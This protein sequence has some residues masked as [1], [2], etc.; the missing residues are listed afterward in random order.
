MTAEYVIER[1]LIGHAADHANSLRRGLE[2]TADHT[3]DRRQ[4]ALA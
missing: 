3:H 4:E 1:V 2:Q